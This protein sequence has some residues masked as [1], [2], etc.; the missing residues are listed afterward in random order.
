MSEFYFIRHGQTDF[1]I[2]KNHDK[3]EHP[4]HVPLN[5]TGRAQALAI[6]PVISLLPIKTICCSPYLRAQETKDLIAARL[7]VSMIDVE[8]LGECNAQIWRELAAE[9]QSDLT[10]SFH[11]RVRNGLEAA[12][13]QEGP[14][15]IVAHGGVHWA[16]CS[17]LNVENHVK[18][19]DNCIP[20]HFS[21]VEG[22]WKARAL[23]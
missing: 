12:L 21:I 23:I 14:V 4:P 11:K 22:K 1:N 7:T 17:L 5:A 6:E 18:A 9:R 19:I 13:A 8:D 3:I 15:L 2:M 10:D 16:I 20:V